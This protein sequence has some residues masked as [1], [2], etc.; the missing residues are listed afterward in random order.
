MRFSELHSNIRIRIIMFFFTTL[1]SNMILPFMAIYFSYFFGQSMAGLMVALEVVIATIATLY[2]GYF[3]DR[4]GRKRVM[5]IAEWIRFVSLV[6]AALMNSPWIHSPFI[7]FVMLTVASACMGL[8]TPA[9][10]AMVID[11]SDTQNRKIIY[12]TQ[13]WSMNGAMALGALLGSILFD[14]QRFLLFCIVALVSLVYVLILQ[15]FVIETYTSTPKVRHKVLHEMLLNYRMVAR[16][17]RFLVFTVA[18]LVALS[19]EFQARNYLGVRLASHFKSQALFSFGGH[20]ISINGLKLFG[21]L[22]TENTLLVICLGFLAGKIV[23]KLTEKQALYTGILVNAAAYGFIGFSNNA[24]ALFVFMIFASIGELV[25]WPVS[26][27]MTAELTREESRSSYMAIFSLIPR[28]AM[29]IG[30]LAISFGAY[31]PAWMMGVLF[32]FT[33]IISVALFATIHYK[34]RNKIPVEFEDVS[35]VV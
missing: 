35:S 14:K 3:S 20:S 5:I 21:V 22:N 34:E 16:D 31:L 27:A 7:T 25:Y 33:G 4:I 1:V 26:Q 28:G 6:T 32:F 23:N 8:S 2:G 15:F 11:V 18:T 9:A 30:S 29:L 24:W 17:T 13:Y 12:S 10:Q 19:I